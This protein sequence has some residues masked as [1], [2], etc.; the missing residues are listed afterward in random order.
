MRVGRLVIRRREF[1]PASCSHA[2]LGWELPRM[3]LYA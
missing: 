3:A 2:D 1:G